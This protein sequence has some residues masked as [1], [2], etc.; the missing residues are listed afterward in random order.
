MASV[1]PLASVLDGI[2]PSPTNYRPEDLASI[3]DALTG[4][5]GRQFKDVS[6]DDA[7]GAYSHLVSKLGQ[8]MAQKLITHVMLFNQR[9]DMQ[10]QSPEKRVQSFYSM[11][12]NDPDIDGLLR[13]TGQF[14]QGPVAGMYDSPDTNNQLAQGVDNLKNLPS[15]SAALTPGGS[16]TLKF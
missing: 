11:G 3:R 15:R 16:T 12:S 13:T 10:G 6:S 4:L 1:S 8:P 14:A 5:V 2:G 7:R 9:P